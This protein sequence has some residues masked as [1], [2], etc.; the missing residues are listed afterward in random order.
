MNKHLIALSCCLL[1]IQ[2]TAQNK[3]NPVIEVERLYEADLMDVSK[4]LLGT[5]VPD[6]LRTYNT[7]FQYSIFDKPLNNLY[8]FA[9]LPGASL[10]PETNRPKQHGFVR[11]AM[12][13][14]IMPE[15]DLH[16]QAPLG[17]Q[18]F[19]G[20]NASH[21]SFWG[22]LPVTDGVKEKQQRMTNIGS[23]RL[24]HHN[25]LNVQYME[26]DFESLYHTFVLPATDKQ[27]YFAGGGHLGLYSTD[28]TARELH[29]ALDLGYRHAQNNL[30]LAGLDNNLRENR[31]DIY[32]LAG[33]NFHRSLSFNLE[34]KVRFVS[35][36]WSTDGESASHGSASLLPHVIWSG[37][38]F[39]LSGGTRL[40]LLM[41]REDKSTFIIYPWAKAHFQLIPDNLVVYAQVDA[42]QEVNSYQERLRENPWL[43]GPADT[44]SL[45][46]YAPLTAEA[47][48]NGT[49]ADRFNYRVYVAYRHTDRQ[50]FYDRVRDGL[51]ATLPQTAVQYRL[52]YDN[53]T[54]Y[55]IGGSLGYQNKSF[56]GYV[57]ANWYKY[58]MDSSLP[59]YY[60][61]SFEAAA[62]LRYNWRERIVLSMEAKYRSSVATSQEPL[63]ACTH[64]SA[65]A[66]WVFNRHFSAFLYGD[67]LLNQNI[68]IYQF[69]RRPGIQA[70]A[71]ITVRF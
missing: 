15:G 60:K 59:P 47:G 45:L 38:R 67:N 35:N 13:Y 29:Y 33:Y 34:G 55:G 64:L 8:A 56:E 46:P 1:C 49:L 40:S 54:R 10:A 21:R 12:A 37:E 32:S 36:R 61:P 28:T 41:E 11:L 69:Y 43:T 52:V 2:V 44:T 22:E 58:V 14:P 7:S 3:I 68:G 70:G 17:R 20:L 53:E 42:S 25:Q 5:R 24:E 39:L 23:L 16:L 63:P 31:L 50:Y 51:D 65:Q 9:P 30:S 66:E 71:G 26:T 19:L 62:H 57:S 48:F 6:S 4:P 18:T 27:R